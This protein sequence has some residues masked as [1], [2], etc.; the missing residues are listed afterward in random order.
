MKLKNL[1][2]E[3]QLPMSGKSIRLEGAIFYIDTLNR[4][5][6]KKETLPKGLSYEQKLLYD[7]GGEFHQRAKELLLKM[8]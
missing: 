5:R 4:V 2:K 7:A 3:A 8:K 6:V 1:I